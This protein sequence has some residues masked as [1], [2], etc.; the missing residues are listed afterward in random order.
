MA[1][2]YLWPDIRMLIHLVVNWFVSALALWLVA[3]IIPGIEVRDFPAALVATIIIAVV[4]VTLGT[5]L[6]ILGIPFIILTLGLF[7][8]VINAFLLKVAALF[9]PGFRIRG[10]LNAVL[11]SVL[12]TVLTYIL[13]EAVRFGA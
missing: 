11:G 13:R 7:L 6:K 3:R 2:H 1:Y 8:L 5:I 10:F 4:N 12:L 9:T